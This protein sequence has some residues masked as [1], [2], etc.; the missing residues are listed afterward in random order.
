MHVTTWKGAIK[1]LS[2][3]SPGGGLF[4]GWM[5][6]VVLPPPYKYPEYLLD[7][8][9]GRLDTRLF[10][11]PHAMGLL[12]YGGSSAP[13]GLV[14]LK[15]PRSSRSGHSEHFGDSFTGC[16]TGELP[17]G[18]FQCNL[19]CN[20]YSVTF[21]VRIV[22]VNLIIVNVLQGFIFSFNSECSCAE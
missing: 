3:S 13:S 2:S 8:R 1:V 22:I 9:K 12:R 19:T 14:E 17:T 10:T 7:L 15:M 20:Q 16:Q 4:L 18:P 11:P 5:N 21:T 6:I